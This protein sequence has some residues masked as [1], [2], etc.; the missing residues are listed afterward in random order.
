MKEKKQE[1]ENETVT[2]TNQINEQNISLY[3]LQNENQEIRKR[4]MSKSKEFDKLYRD[5]CKMK[6]ESD[7]GALKNNAENEKLN[8]ALKETEKKL[9]KEKEINKNLESYNSKLFEENEILMQ[10]KQAAKSL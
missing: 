5:F 3:K 8:L 10:E 6:E 9:F 7:L 4:Y 1:L 2:F